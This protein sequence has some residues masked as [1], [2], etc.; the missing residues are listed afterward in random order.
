MY[1]QRL[2]RKQF[3][4]PREQLCRCAHLIILSFN[5]GAPRTEPTV[6]AS[7]VG[8][9]GP[10]VKNSNSSPGHSCAQGDETRLDKTQGVMRRFYPETRT[11]LCPT[12]RCGG[13]TSPRSCRT[14]QPYLQLYSMWYYHSIPGTKVHP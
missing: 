1:H 13:T 6:Y 9:A 7:G 14:L 2:D 12:S 8:G 3:W 11:S 5:W 10:L 4:A